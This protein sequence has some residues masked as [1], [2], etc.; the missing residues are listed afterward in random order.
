[1]T[2]QQALI[3]IIRLFSLFTMARV[4]D[5]MLQRVTVFSE[6]PESLIQFTV[7][8]AFVLYTAIIFYRDPRPLVKVILRKGGMIGSQPT[9]FGEWFAIGRTLLGFWLLGEGIPQLAV[10]IPLL[11]NGASSPQTISHFLSAIAKGL[12]AVVLIIG[13][14][15]GSVTPPTD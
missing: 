7:M 3:I 4:I 2:P 13:W 12:C 8:T 1:M 6:H 11:A 5:G 10:A 15:K 9:Q 14:P